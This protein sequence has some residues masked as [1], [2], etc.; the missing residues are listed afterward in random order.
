M[1]FNTPGNQAGALGNDVSALAIAH[2]LRFALHRRQPTLE[3][4]KLS[5]MNI[6]QNTQF[7]KTHRLTLIFKHLQNKLARRQGVII[8][9]CLT[10]Q[11]WI[12]FSYF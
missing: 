4:L 7:F 2:Q 6:E 8:F 1:P 10:M 3:H 9:A 11:L 12:A 5:A